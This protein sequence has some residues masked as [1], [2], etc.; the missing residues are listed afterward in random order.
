M[1]NNGIPSGAS[2]PDAL[3]FSVASLRAEASHG[4]GFCHAAYGEKVCGLSRVAVALLAHIA[5]LVRSL[6]HLLVKSVIQHFLG[7]SIVALTPRTARISGITYVM[8]ADKDEVER[9]LQ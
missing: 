8:D 7:P 6:C 9:I 5:D 1:R 3:V 4:C 2:A